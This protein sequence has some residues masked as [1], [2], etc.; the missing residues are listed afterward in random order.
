MCMHCRNLHGY[1]DTLFKLRHFGIFPLLSLWGNIGNHVGNEIPKLICMLRAATTLYSLANL[2]LSYRGEQT[3]VRVHKATSRA[4]SLSLSPLLSSPPDAHDIF[5]VFYKKR[6][7]QH[8]N[9][10]G[11]LH[12]FFSEV[13]TLVV[14]W[15]TT[16]FCLLMPLPGISGM[17]D[18]P[19]FTRV[20]W[21]VFVYHLQG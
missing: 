11:H 13:G 1:L 14:F 3:R 8:P 15:S 4:R 10:C 20:R 17:G 16:I 21:G 19:G 2:N 12:S 5:T 7:M 6:G 18:G 9:L